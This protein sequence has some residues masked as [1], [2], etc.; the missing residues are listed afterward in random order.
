MA[1]RHPLLL[2]F[3]LAF[4]IS[5]S[6][7]LPRVASEQGWWERSVPEWWH[8]AGAAGPIA[9]A[10]IVAAL[11]EG[12]TGI[13]ALIRQYRPSRTAAG[14]LLFAWS[15]LLISFAAGLVAARLADGVW[16]AYADIAKASN[17]PAIGLP[18]TFLV[19]L[20][21]SGSVKKP[22]GEDS[23]FHDFNSRIERCRR[24]DSYF[25]VGRSGTYRRSS[26]IPRSRTWTPL[27]SS[28][29]ALG[30]RWARCFS[31][32]YTTAAM[33]VCSRWYCGMDCSTRLRHLKPDPASSPR[34]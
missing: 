13:L 30:W 15:S 32:G 18:L 9:A 22:A 21:S 10:L 8:Y 11:T 7:W 19:H 3:G 1:N 27:R 4:A 16:P 31:R 28:V 14:W 24:R 6:L 2:Y 17:L 26:R 25:L 33:E 23:R 29:G 34:L 12:R 20:L 5:W